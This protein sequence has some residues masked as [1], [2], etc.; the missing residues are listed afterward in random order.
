VLSAE[1]RSAGSTFCQAVSKC[2][3]STGALLA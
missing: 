2:N 3:T 1:G